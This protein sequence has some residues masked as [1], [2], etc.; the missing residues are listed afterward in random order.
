MAKKLLQ[1]GFVLALGAA[2]LTK[3]K[4]E[5]VAAQLVKSGAI[6]GREAKRLIGSILKEA[7]KEQIKLNT[8]IAKEVKGELKKAKPHIGKIKKKAVKVSKQLEKRGRSVAKR[9][10]KS[11]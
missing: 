1:K 11:L 4:A 9:I 3:S 2:S 8:F 10:L 7:R 6:T 5:K